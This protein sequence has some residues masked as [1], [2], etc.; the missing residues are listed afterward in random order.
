M[1]LNTPYLSKWDVCIKIE[2]ES[3][4][5]SVQSYLINQLGYIWKGSND[6]FTLR[7]YPSNSL[8]HVHQLDWWIMLDKKNKEMS[9]YHSI[10]PYDWKVVS[11]EDILKWG[12]VDKIGIREAKINSII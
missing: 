7:S 1:S 6:G 5:D 4:W 3:Q 2:G 12:D 9:Q 11:V 8:S 10:I